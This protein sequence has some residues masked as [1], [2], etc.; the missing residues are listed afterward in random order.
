MNVKNCYS[1][2]EMMLDEANWTIKDQNA[3][4][5][6]WIKSAAYNSFSQ[7]KKELKERPSYADKEVGNETPLSLQM[8]V[9]SG[10]GIDIAW[11]RKIRD[12][13]AI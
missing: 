6:D 4:Q 10:G 2:Q 7:K 12:I 1:N 3:G 11:D 5:E 13:Y 9:P 8:F